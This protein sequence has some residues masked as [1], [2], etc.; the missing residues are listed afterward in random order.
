[1]MN[2]Q[3]AKIFPT[4]EEFTE[5]VWGA[6]TTMVTPGEQ[7][8]YEFLEDATEQEI[9]EVKSYVKKAMMPEAHR[10]ARF[11][12]LGP[13]D[14]LVT[15]VELEEGGGRSE[16][17]YEMLHVALRF[18]LVPG[19]DTRF[20]VDAEAPPH[21]NPHVDVLNVHVSPRYAV[22]ECAL[23]NSPEA[24]HLMVI[25]HETND[26]P[27]WEDLQRVKNAVVGPDAWGYEVFPAQ[28][29]AIDDANVRHIFTG[30]ALPVVL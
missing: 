1:M 30:F 29:R 11:F 12:G 3:I 16:I 19:L 20:K 28:E 17:G 6:S 2:A 14:V 23:P 21:P 15:D 13:H 5:N 22:V 26:R 25:P 8:A 18:R 9:D 10:Q 27:H 24:R 7:H 4:L